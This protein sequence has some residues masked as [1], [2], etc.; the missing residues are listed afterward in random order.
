MHSFKAV[1]GA[2]GFLLIIWQIRE[3]FIHILDTMKTYENPVGEG[4]EE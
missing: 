2:Q 4:N 3:I 1:E